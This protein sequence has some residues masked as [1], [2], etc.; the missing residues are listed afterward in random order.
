MNT[1]SYKGSKRKLL[2]HILKLSTGKTFFDGFSGSGI[3]SA[4]MRANG[5]TVS[6]NDKNYSSFIYSSVFL[7]G[8]EQ[9]VVDHH[10]AE[11]NGLDGVAGW[12]T[13]HYGGERFRKSKRSD[14]TTG[15][16]P[17]AFTTEN[18]M[19]LDAARDYI[20]GLEINSNDKNALIF[21]CLLASN[22]AMNNGAD[23]KS[24][25]KQWLPKALK[26]V[27]FA[28]PENIS[29]PKGTVHSGDIFCVGGQYDTIYFDPPYT[30]TLNYNSAYHI[31]DSIAMWDKPELDHDYALPRPARA[32]V[33]GGGFYSKKTIA[34]DFRRLVNAFSGRIIISY[35]DAPRNLISIDELVSVLGSV[36]VIS[37]G[38]KLS[39]QFTCQ[40]KQ[41]TKL[42]EYLIVL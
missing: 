38:H 22:Q 9:K 6:S 24:S 3:V 32:C 34:D 11:M 33:S 39:T 1:I 4:H 37:V 28:A 36:D 12:L 25:F 7:N 30:A 10:V 23:Q 17:S 40:Q 19:K 20:D 13:Q 16:L 27:K 35:S 29:G 42:N 31:N 14:G 21:S 5:F 15:I 26:P 8:Y 41:S 18:S 2:D